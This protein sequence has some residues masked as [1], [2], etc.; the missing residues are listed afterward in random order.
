MTRESEVIAKVSMQMVRNVLRSK[1]QYFMT[2]TFVLF[3]KDGWKT[4]R[5]A[6]L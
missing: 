6:S 1:T 5:G 2:N 3:D 4:Y